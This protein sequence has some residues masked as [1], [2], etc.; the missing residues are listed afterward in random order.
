MKSLR[1]LAFAGVLALAAPLF[2]SATTTPS[3]NRAVDAENRIVN[4]VGHELRMLPY[5]S[6]FDDLSY[7]VNGN[8]VTLYGDVVRPILKSDA[9]NV[10]KRIEGVEEVINKIQVLPLSSFDDSIRWRAMRAI[11]GYPML[12]RY[13]MGTQ[14]SI[15]IIVDNG[16]VTLR[17]VVDSETDKNVAYLRANGVSG[18]F[19]VTNDLRVANPRS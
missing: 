14:P 1:S 19:S 6:I 7:A 8:T 3:M 17:G 4:K 10:V 18:V 12:Q 9:Q 15:H 13:G 2:L 5:Y 11:Y 16:H